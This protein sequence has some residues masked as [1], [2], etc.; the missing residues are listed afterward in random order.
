[1]CGLCATRCKTRSDRT[2]AD[3]FEGEM[4]TCKS[5]KMITWWL[6]LAYLQASVSALAIMRSMRI[7][8]AL[9]GVCSAH[10]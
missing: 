4:T 5:E 10:A 9:R 8:D 1:V 7:V 2:T 3:L 6:A